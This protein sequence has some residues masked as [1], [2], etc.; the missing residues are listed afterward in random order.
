MGWGVIIPLSSESVGPLLH[1]YS[2]VWAH[3]YIGALINQIW[4]GA[5]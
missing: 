4:P 5:G 1:Y 3:Q 2:L